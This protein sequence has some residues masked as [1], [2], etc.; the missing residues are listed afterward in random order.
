MNDLELICSLG[1]Y[2]ITQ[3][4]AHARCV[5]GKLCESGF[6]FRTLFWRKFISFKLHKGTI[7]TITMLHRTCSRYT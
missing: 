3:T 5:T 7:F 6:E 2:D 1:T 4:C